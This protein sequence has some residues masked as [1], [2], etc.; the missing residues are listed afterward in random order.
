MQLLVTFESNEQF[1]TL[2]V[3]IDM[4]LPDLM[5]LIEIE[6]EI[7]ANKQIIYFQN[8][9]LTPNPTDTLTTYGMADGDMILVRSKDV[10]NEILAQ[11]RH[12]M[13]ASSYAG[14]SSEDID[15]NGDNFNETN[16]YQGI[17]QVRIQMLSNPTIKSGVLQ[18]YP[19]LGDKI[20]DVQAFRA[21]MVKI[22]RERYIEEKKRKA[23]LKKLQDD[24]YDPESQQI[25]L[26]NIRADAITE[27]F[28]IA[29]E[30]NPEVFTSVSMLFI[31]IKV[32]G[33]SVKAFVDSGAQATIMS[34][35]CAEACNLS[36]L[37]DK[38]FQGIAMGV[39]TAKI[40]GRIHTAPI[41]VG[42]ALLAASFTVMEG[43]NVD[44]LLGLDLLKKYQAQIDLKENK[45]RISNVEVPFLPE[46]QIPKS[47][48]NPNSP[49]V[50]AIT[51][52][53]DSPVATSSKRI[54]TS[55]ATSRP[56]STVTPP[57][58]VAATSRP[59]YD[60]SAISNL[61]QLGFSRDQV[62]QALDQ[63]G[64]NAEMAAAILFES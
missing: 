24:P 31:E 44:F 29:M 35:E 38:R 41:L 12:A 52:S 19:Q 40:L 27:N 39:G 11:E 33:K 8:K 49:E 51:G 13:G 56:S 47:F 1:L 63:T 5:G 9:Q 34:P 53:S 15:V 32:N 54:K 64:G 3:G 61:V 45:L 59:R 16:L 2:D 50:T 22:E 62:L 58:A 20:N 43:K 18:S 14:S 60:E 30:E 48:M 37:I 25:I 17:E 10:I 6:G 36:H 4:T 55:A 21:E 7:P 23:A 57:V 26:N 46:N 42:E 28:N